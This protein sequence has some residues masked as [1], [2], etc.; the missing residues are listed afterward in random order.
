MAFVYGTVNSDILNAADG[1]TSGDDDVYG[2]DGNDTIRGLGGEDWLYGQDGRDKV[3]GGA[4]NDWIEGGKGN[5]DLFGGDNNDILWGDEGN[6]K[7]YGEDDN[8]YLD[9]GA[10]ADRLDGGDGI[11]DAS[12]YGSEEGVHVSLSPFLLI[13]GGNTGGDAEGDTLFNIENL[14]GSK[15]DDELYGNDEANVLWGMEGNDVIIGGDG[16]EGIDTLSY[17]GS[18]DGVTVSLM[19]D[20]ASGGDA[21]GDQLDNIEIL[22]GSAYADI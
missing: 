11:D 3:Y 2:G 9:G 4:D 16:G 8:D 5:D 10:G 17:A 7:L 1:I 12:Y 15:H 6:D 19:D 20:T 14:Y 18:S 22:I 21:D 13:G